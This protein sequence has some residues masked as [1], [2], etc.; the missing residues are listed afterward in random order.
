MKRVLPPAYF[1]GAIVLAVALH[2]V[3]SIYELWTFPWRL[4]GLVPLVLGIALNLLGT[5]TLT[6]GLAARGA[7][8]ELQ[9]RTGR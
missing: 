2:F 7:T 3:L 1:L 4:F 9:V 6:V 8:C 5:D